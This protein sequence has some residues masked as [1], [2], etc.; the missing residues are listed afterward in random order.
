MRHIVTAAQ[1]KAR[2]QY[3]ITEIG[4]PS[5]VLM[6][7]A[8]YAIAEEVLSYLKQSGRSGRVLC[9][10]GSGNN[11]GDGAAC[12]RILHMKGIRADLCLAGKE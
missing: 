12:A 2:D 8:S 1:M 7:R 9:V 6:E 4:V 5:S 11:G 10:C 3:T